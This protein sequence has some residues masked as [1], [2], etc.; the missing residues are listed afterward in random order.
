MFLNTITLTQLYRL[1]SITPLHF[2]KNKY[3]SL[4]N[5]HLSNCQCEKRLRLYTIYCLLYN[6]YRQI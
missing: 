6:N 4:S 2:L 5:A 3:Q 1:L